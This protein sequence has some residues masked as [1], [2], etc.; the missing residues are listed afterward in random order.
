VEFPADGI[1][2]KFVQLKASSEL[3][4]KKWLE[5]CSLA[6]DHVTSFFESFMQFA[7]KLSSST[8]S[9]DGLSE[10]ILKGENVV[11]PELSMFCEPREPPIFVHWLLEVM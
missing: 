8:G 7:W 2:F 10:K 4:N 9:G 5:L 11:I 1:I 3:S 6:V